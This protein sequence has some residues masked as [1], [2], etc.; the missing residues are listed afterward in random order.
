MTGAY[1]SG[2]ALRVAAAGRL[3]A[4]AVP[5]LWLATFLVL[6]LLIVLKIS[7]AEAVIAQPPY[8]PLASFE[9]GRLQLAF[10]LANYRYLADDALYAKAYLSSVQIALTATVLALLIGYPLAY[11]IARARR[12]LRTLLLMLVILPFWTSFLL[13][14]YAWIGLLKANGVL[15]NILLTLGLIDQPLVI[16]HT[17]I[18]VYIGIVYAYLPFM[19]L[20]LYANLVRLDWSLQEASADLGASATATFMRITLPQSWPG[21]VAGSMLVFIPAVGE[22]VIPDLLGGPQTL[23][24]GKVLWGEFFSNHDWPVAAA[25]AMALLAVLIL[26][27]ALLPLRRRAEAAG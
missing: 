7:F 19:V 6:P 23:M 2:K 9:D 16:L 4:T 26:P 14:V 21:I 3:L 1:S 13:R 22:F 5:A 15:N 17:D 10:N 8:A 18:A 20:P 27:L 11:F 24:I 12:G 25:V